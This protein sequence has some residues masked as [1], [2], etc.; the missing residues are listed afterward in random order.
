[1]I[2]RMFY[3]GMP[4]LLFSFHSFAKLLESLE[5]E[6]KARTPYLAYLVNSH[7]GL[8]AT[9]AHL[10]RLVERVERYAFPCVPNIFTVILLTT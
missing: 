8:L 2:S 9:H 4:L 7:Q 1:M 5:K 6:Y 3:W 10:E